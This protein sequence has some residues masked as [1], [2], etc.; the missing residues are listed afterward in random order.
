MDVYLLMNEKYLAVER[1]MLETIKN[2]KKK[3][4]EQDRHERG[5]GRDSSGS[6]PF[7]GVP[8]WAL[9]LHWD[10]PGSGQGSDQ[11]NGGG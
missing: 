5:G 6:E 7:Q 3:K 1:D 11:D 2:L 9:E 4:K 8:V 10:A